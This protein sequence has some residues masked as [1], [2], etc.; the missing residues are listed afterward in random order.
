[1]VIYLVFPFESIEDFNLRLSPEHEI[2]RKS[3]REFAEK[4]IGPRALEIDEKDEI[5]RDLL[6]EM[7]Q[8]GYFGIGIPETYGGQGEDH[9]SVVILT[10]E[11][12]RISP[13]L[14]VV[15]GT[16]EL[17]A[18]PI[19]LFGSEEQRK[20]YLPPIA[21]GEKFGAFAVTEP[22]CGSDVAGIQTRAEKKGDKWV[23]NGRKAFISNADLADYILVL[24]RTSPPPDRR[25]RH[26][27]L[28]FFIVEKD[29]PG[30]KLDQKYEKM[31]L[32]GSHIYELSLENVI[33][34]DENRVGAEDLGFLIAMETFD[35]TRIGVAAQALGIAQRLFEEA[36]SYV[37]KRQAF[38]YPLAFFQAVQFSLV[39]ILAK[40][41]AS[42][43]LTYLAAKLADE[44]RREFTFV[45]SLAKFFASEMAEEIASRVINLHGGVGV[46]RETGI[47]RF[48]RDIKIIQ[49]YEGT[50]DIQRLVAYRQLIRILREKNLIP[51]EV[52]RLVV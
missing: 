35:R 36:M 48:L 27:G 25:S 5:P 6:E 49:I 13:A 7:A 34:P 41:M 30:F 44:G 32:R 24:A 1:M 43:Y 50:N 29:T 3:V 37:H 47:E 26:M 17:F 9:T 20:R 45:A 42:R 51:E 12:S 19:I 14:T 38:G 4:K 23:I 16:N 2:F 11:I 15:L 40:L 33:V 31:G 8:Q 28:T 18:V 52:A 39:E 22:C 21:R 46:I 10:E